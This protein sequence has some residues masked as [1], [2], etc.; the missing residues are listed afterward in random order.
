[1]PDSNRVNEYIRALLI[2]MT[3]HSSQVNIQTVNTK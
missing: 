1:M 3:S 2:Q